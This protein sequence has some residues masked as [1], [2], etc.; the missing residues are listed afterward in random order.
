MK[1]SFVSVAGILVG[2]RVFVVVSSVTCMPVL[3]VDVKVFE[4]VVKVEAERLVGALS[5]SVLCF[6]R[7]EG[8]HVIKLVILSSSGLI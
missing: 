6:L 1:V 2:S 8:R 7:E 3:A 5:V 4:H